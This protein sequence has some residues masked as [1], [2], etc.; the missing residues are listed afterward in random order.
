MTGSDLYIT[1]Q[2]HVRLCKL[3]SEP[4][5]GQVRTADLRKFAEELSGMKIVDQLEVD[6]AVV[7]MYSR[8]R[9]MDICTKESLAVML[10]LPEEADLNLGKLSVVTPLGTALLGRSAGDVFEWRS[11]SGLRRLLIKEVCYQPEAAGNYNL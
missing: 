7:T 8:V 5:S 1:K 3:I 10:V 11:S 9:V 6:A 4:A 2:D